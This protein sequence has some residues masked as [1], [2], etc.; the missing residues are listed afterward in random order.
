MTYG[1]DGVG[2]VVAA[3]AFACLLLSIAAFICT[4]TFRFFI[5]A[6]AAEY[7]LVWGA[8]QITRKPPFQDRSTLP[9]VTT[10]V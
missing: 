6:D 7:T 2:L 4:L 3:G 1:T 8:N 5:F 9:S 10:Q